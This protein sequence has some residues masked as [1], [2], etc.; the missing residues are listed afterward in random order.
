MNNKSED[1][2]L[3]NDSTE[4][5]KLMR[6]RQQLDDGINGVRALEQQ[7]T[8]NI[9]LIELG[10]EEGDADVVREAEEALKGLKT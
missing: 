2:T 10:E 5:Q 4:A 8:D 7:L 9:E 1:P 3:W 6:E